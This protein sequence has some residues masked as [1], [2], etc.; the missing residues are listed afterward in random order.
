MSKITP[1]EYV[2]AQSQLSIAGFLGIKDRLKAKDKIEKIAR[3]WL[4]DERVVEI[5][6]TTSSLNEFET[7]VRLEIERADAQAKVDAQEQ[8]E[9]ERQVNLYNADATLLN[10]MTPARRRAY[11]LISLFIL[12]C[13]VYVVYRF[14]DTI[15]RLVIGGL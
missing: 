7:I 14:I 8:E 1:Q 3:E 15:A 6:K 5:V 11:T 9:A 13:M 2:D 12:G 4:I 10:G